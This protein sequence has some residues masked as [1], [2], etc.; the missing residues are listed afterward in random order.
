MPPFVPLG[1]DHLGA[2]ALT[3]VLAIGAARSVRRASRGTAL[4]IRCAIATLLATTAAVEVGRGAAEGWL[5]VEALLPLHLCDAAL[6]LAIV[7]LLWPR[8]W[9]AELLYFWTFGGTS[10]AMLLPDLP[11]GFPRWE[12]AA[13][14]TLHGLV[15]VAAATLVFGLG[16]TPRRGAAL[17]VFAVTNG[18]ALVVAVVNLALDANYLY[19]RAKPA[20]PT[21]LDWFGPW[22]VYILA[23]DAAALAVYWLLALPFRRADECP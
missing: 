20:N 18:Y 13:F 14:F 15:I 5:T 9:L 12:F 3:A 21:L 23:A 1:L 16:L 19:L 22:P 6:L 11:V 10:F 2:L 8:A 4:A 7:G 17:R